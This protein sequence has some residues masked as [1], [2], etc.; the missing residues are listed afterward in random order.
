MNILKLFTKSV[1]GASFGGFL[2]LFAMD[3]I[4]HGNLAVASL[5][6]AALL[7]AVIFGAF[8]VLCIRPVKN[9]VP[10]LPFYSTV[11]LG[12]CSMLFSLIIIAFAIP[13]NHPIF[14][15]RV[16]AMPNF[17]QVVLVAYAYFAA[18]GGYY[19]CD[20]SKLTGKKRLAP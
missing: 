19:G 11:L 5:A 13:G 10:T 9:T 6:I 12:W 4:F 3:Q 1:L 20:I 8:V 14:P 17:S 15:A 16:M 18:L 2:F 7:N